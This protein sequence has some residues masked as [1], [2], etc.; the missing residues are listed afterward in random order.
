VLLPLPLL[1]VAADK[2][3]FPKQD[4][5]GWYCSGKQLSDRHLAVHRK[6]RKQHSTAAAAA[7]ACDRMQRM[8]NRHELSCKQHTC[9]QPNE[10][11]EAGRAW[12]QRCSGWQCLACNVPAAPVGSAA[13][14][15]PVMALPLQDSTAIAAMPAHRPPSSRVPLQLIIA[16]QQ[17]QSNTH[18][19]TK[20]PS[21]PSAPWLVR[22]CN[23]TDLRAQ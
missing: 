16:S 9:A 11:Q 5:V 2:T 8:T 3:V 12:K 15:E 17:L 18:Q 4:I 6:V 7:A 13:V 20:C 14:A 10:Q 19:H 1:L 23:T 21:A 22:V